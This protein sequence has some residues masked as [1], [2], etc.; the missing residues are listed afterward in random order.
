MSDADRLGRLVEEAGFRDVDT[1]TVLV[2]FETESP[3]RFTEFMRDV[4]PQLTTML[5]DRPADVQERIWAKIT[6]TYR[7]FESADGRVRT[8]NRSIWV[9]GIK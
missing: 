6:D 9:T 4:A 3:A 2:I 8:E 1:G 7:Q 5:K